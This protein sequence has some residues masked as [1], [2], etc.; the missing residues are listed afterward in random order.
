MWP[1]TVEIKYAESELFIDLT[2]PEAGDQRR[3]PLRR[4]CLNDM[5]AC[6]MWSARYPDEDATPKRPV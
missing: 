4:G 5:G 6:T 3:S 2:Y 1:T